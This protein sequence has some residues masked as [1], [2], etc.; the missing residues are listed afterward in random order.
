MMASRGYFFPREAIADI[1]PGF[2]LPFFPCERHSAYRAIKGDLYLIHS[3]H[4]FGFS[5]HF[6]INCFSCSVIFPL[7]V[8]VS[9]SVVNVVNE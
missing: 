3:P 1:S 5:F 6:K 7:V 8:A 9:K 4:V 2:F